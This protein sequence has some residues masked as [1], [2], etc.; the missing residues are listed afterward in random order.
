M[1][2]CIDH[3]TGLMASL[4]PRSTWG[5]V[6]SHFLQVPPSSAVAQCQA[7]LPLELCTGPL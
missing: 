4:S 6:L 5:P 2:E 7:I 1:V 3:P